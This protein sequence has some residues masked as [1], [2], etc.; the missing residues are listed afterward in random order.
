MATILS[1]LVGSF[2]NKLQA[3]IT[4]EAILILGVKEELIE[5]Q[6]RMDQ[7]QHFLIDAEGRSIKESAVNNWLGQLRDAMYDADDIIDMARFKGNKLL[8]D[9]DSTLSSKQNKCSWLSLSSCFSNLWTRHEIA[10]KIRSLNKRIEGISKDNVFLSLANSESNARGS[11]ST[12]RKSSYL[13]EPNLVGKEIIYACRKVV[14]LVLANKENKSYKAAIVGTGGVVLDDVWQSDTW[15]ELLRTPLQSASTGIILVTTRNDIVAMEIGVDYTHRV[16]LMSVDVGWELLWK[17]MNIKEEKEVQN[18][19]GVGIEIVQKCGGLP[20]GI[21]LIAR[22][23]LSKDQTENEWKKVLRKDAWSMSSLPSEIKGALYLSYEELPHHLKQCFLYCAL[24]PEDEDILREDIV[25]LWVAEGFIDEKDGQL[26]EDTAEEYYYE[27]ISRNLLQPDISYVDHSRCKMHDLLRQLACY[28]SKEE[29]FIGDP[30]SIG[31]NILT[32]IRRILV[33]TKKD[34]VVLP[35]MDKEKY[36]LRT[37]RSSYDKSLRVDNA[38]FTKLTYIRVLDLTGSVFQSI[39]YC[40]GSLIHLRL[41]DLDRTDISDLPESI[42][43]LINLQILNLNRCDA[44]HSLP[45]GITR[46]S[47]LRCLGLS[48][49]PINKVP[50]GIGRL[51]F[52]SDLGGYPVGG[53]SDNNAKMQDGWNLEE[54]GT[55]LQLWKLELFK[56]ER[57]THCNSDSL[58]MDK[59]HLKKLE[60]SCTKRTDEDEAYFEED[61]ISIGKIFEMLIP[62]DNL[63]ELNIYDFFGRRFP[64]WLGTT[65]NLSCVKYLNLNNCKCVVYLPPIGQLANLKYLKIMGAISVTKIGPEFIGCGV[66]NSG[67]TGAVAF[68]KLEFLI[69]EDMPNWEEWT[70]VVEEEEATSACGKDRGEDCSATKQKGEVPPPRMRVLP[71]LKV[72]NLSCCP[73]LRALPG[74]LGQ[75]A[76]SLK[77]LQLRDVHSLKVVEDFPF[78]SKVLAIIDCEGLERVSN[79]PQVRELYV[80]LCPNLRCVERLDNLQ[81]LF[82]TEDMEE[83]SSLWVP[84]L[85][86]QHKQLHV[87]DLDVYTW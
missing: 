18:L 44:L 80:Q 38:I 56:L 30:E 10:V 64:T 66:G 25:R 19:R 40:I 16:D 60:L 74:Q 37:W 69:I 2:A 45:S 49:T 39:P 55:L 7:I 1:S 67:S 13:V 85:E 59:K 17:S 83:V 28:L 42:G 27:L 24:Y 82:L 21:K 76:T 65:T 41:L 15:T 9:H 79:L 23:L 4:E 71:C 86:E 31:S 11:Q 72:V 5:L 33:L 75:E 47:N 78:L 22:V 51:N 35:S 8:P 34:M 57:A 58:L 84:E 70:I 61:A 36:K 14:E 52:L 63:E 6:R 46:L 73:K 77:E 68:P 54:L 87:E 3:I 12:R 26:L 62:P 53:D 29:C 20:L 43:R 81:Q 50:K 32:K 48:E